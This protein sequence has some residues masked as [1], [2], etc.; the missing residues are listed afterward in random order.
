MPPPS[1]CSRRVNSS[2]YM[3]GLGC[4]PKHVLAFAP[5]AGAEFV[6][7][8]RVENAQRLGRVAADVEAVDR[9]MLDH[10]IRIDDEGRAERDM[11]VLVQ[12]PERLGELAAS[13]GDPREVRA[14]ELGIPR[15]T[16]PEFLA[17]LL[18]EAQRSVAVGGTSGKSTVTGMIGWFLLAWTRRQDPDLLRRILAV[19]APLTAATLLLLWQTRTG[20]A[21]QVLGLAGAIALLRA[22]SPE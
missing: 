10:I 1:C 18:N 22:S 17:R 20:P 12:D 6:G 19:A 7:L 16:R 8:Q 9:D 14:G 2:F 21:A 15:V 11:L 3:A 4:R 5:V 13:V